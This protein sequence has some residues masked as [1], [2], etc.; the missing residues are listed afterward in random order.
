MP[1]QV[2]LVQLS[3]TTMFFTD[4]APATTRGTAAMAAMRRGA[5]RSW[6]HTM[7]SSSTMTR[8]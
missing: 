2:L 4:H 3:K 5:M 1:A 6:R 8:M 7:A